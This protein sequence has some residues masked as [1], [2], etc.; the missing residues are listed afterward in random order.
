MGFFSYEK[1][2]LFVCYS[3][4][5]MYNRVLCSMHLIINGTQIYFQISL[6]ST[7]IDNGVHRYFRCGSV[8]VSVGMTV[9][10]HIMFN[11][12]MDFT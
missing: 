8:G 7:A 1:A 12:I 3:L 11:Q 4:V 9:Y 10:I 2:L 6:Y 5:Q